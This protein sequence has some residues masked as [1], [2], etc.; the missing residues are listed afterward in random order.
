MEL[1]QRDKRALMALAAGLV[2]I[3]ILR[4]AVSSGNAGPV[5]S[6][7]SAPVAEKRLAKLRQI[8]ATVPGKEAVLKQVS[9][10]LAAREKGV[11]VTDTAPQAQARLLEIARR[12]G[13]AEG[14]DI[15]GGD[16]GSP[17]LLAADYGEVSVGVGFECRIEQFINFLAALS[18]EA[19][20]IAPADIRIT[21]ANTTEKTVGVRITL[22]GV[23]PRKLVPVKKGFSS[24]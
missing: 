21:S 13:K 15:R 19:D 9:L 23:V 22:S 20:L 14:I 24:F 11:I 8:A 5:A 7:D 2:A 1:K 18:R 3:L 10:E 16:F 17:K 4:F 6:L 12:V